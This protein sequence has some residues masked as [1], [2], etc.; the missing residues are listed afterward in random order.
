V[1]WEKLTVELWT[2]RGPWDGQSE[3]SGRSALRV[4]DGLDAD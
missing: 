1:F 4:V 3:T 2:V